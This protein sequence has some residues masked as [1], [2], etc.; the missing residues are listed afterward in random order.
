MAEESYLKLLATTGFQDVRVAEA[1]PIPLSDE[2]LVG[3]MS[4]ADIAAFRASGV[5]LKSVTV[6]GTKPAS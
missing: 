6:L 5:A 1:R 3:S 2:A 4:A